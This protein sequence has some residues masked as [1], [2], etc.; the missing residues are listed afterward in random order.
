MDLEDLINYFYP[1]LC[2]TRLFPRGFYEK[3]FKMKREF[4]DKKCSRA[5]WFNHSRQMKEKVHMVFFGEC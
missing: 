2:N 3:R 5:E 1:L 4:D